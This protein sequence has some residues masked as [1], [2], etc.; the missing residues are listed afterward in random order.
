[1]FNLSS[2]D[3]AQAAATNAQLTDMDTKFSD[4][5]TNPFHNSSRASSGCAD[6]PSTQ[7]AIITNP[8]STPN[9]SV[10]LSGVDLMMTPS[11]QEVDNP[12]SSSTALAINP[13]M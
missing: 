4:M 9:C 10:D 3:F 2:S 12:Y 7:P 1:M 13:Y 5:L 8:Y 6:Q 11:T